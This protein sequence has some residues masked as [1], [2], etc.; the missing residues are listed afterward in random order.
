MVA[1]A[2]RPRHQGVPAVPRQN[3]GQGGAF[4]RLSA[5]V[6]LC[7]AGE[8]PGAERPEARGRHP[9]SR[10]GAL[11]GRSGHCACARHHQRGPAAVLKREAAHLQPLPTPRRA[12]IAA[13]QP[14]ATAA[15][16]SRIAQPSPL[17]H[18][19]HVYDA[20]LERESFSGSSE[21]FREILCAQM[22]VS[23]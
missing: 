14:Q 16:V 5:P 18:S 11:A 6:V 22:C 20:L 15:V 17:Q 3:Q 21:S 13:A 7:A 4:Q 9:Q 19:R 8:P 1:F 12:D 10:G 23:L 2:E